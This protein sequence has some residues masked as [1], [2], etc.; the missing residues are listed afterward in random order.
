MKKNAIICPSCNTAFKVDETN[1][2]AIVKQIR[3]EQFQAEIEGRLQLAA[4]EKEHAVA[5]AEEKLRNSLLEEL[6]EKNKKIAAME[7]ANKLS[8]QE[9]LIEQEKAY[10]TR[11][12][13]KEKELTELAAQIKNAGLQQ[14]IE[15]SNA[16]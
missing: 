4:K 8:M 6:A 11:M 5:L 14:Q 3:D 9:A 1:Y 2:A 16:V 13:A 15:V 7:A 10:E 12:Q